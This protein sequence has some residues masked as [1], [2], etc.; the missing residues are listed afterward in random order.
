MSVDSG[1][2]HSMVQAVIDRFIDGRTFK[3]DPAHTETGSWFFNICYGSTIPDVVVEWRP[4]ER[5]FIV[6]GEFDSTGTIAHNNN[7]VIAAV[8]AIENKRELNRRSLR[9]A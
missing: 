4:T 1:P 9:E 8:I 6:A 5:R 7:G 2:F 3:I